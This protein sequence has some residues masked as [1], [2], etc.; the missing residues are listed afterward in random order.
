MCLMKVN[1]LLPEV[2]ALLQEMGLAHQAVLYN[3]CGYRD[4]FYTRD[5]E[6]LEGQPVDYMSLL[7]VRKRT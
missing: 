5:L 4:G 3:R 6:H 2:A 7:I 1:R